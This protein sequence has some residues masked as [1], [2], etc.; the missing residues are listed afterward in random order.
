MNGK[1][2]EHSINQNV[3]FYGNNPDEKESYVKDFNMREER[4]RENE[5]K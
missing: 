5:E 1:E 3:F 2:R 4:K